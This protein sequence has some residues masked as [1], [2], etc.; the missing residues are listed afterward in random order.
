MNVYVESNFVLQLALLQ[1]FHASEEES[2]RWESVRARLLRSADVV[3]IDGEILATAS[4]Q[5]QTYALEPHDAIVY[6]SVLS[7]LQR[8]GGVASC[9]LNADAKDFDDPNLVAELAGHHC[10]LIFRF[11]DG[12]RYLSHAR[13]PE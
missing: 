4:R 8:S 3:P 5:R 2:R 9:F 1:E 7:H 11:D 13:T 10:K 6:T 12:L